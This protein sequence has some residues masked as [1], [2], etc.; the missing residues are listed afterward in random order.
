MIDDEALKNIERLHQLKTDGIISEEEFAQGKERLLFG[1]RPQR[2]AATPSLGKTIINPEIDEHLRW[3]LLPLKR[4]LDFEGRS[5]RREF[6]MFLLLFSALVAVLAFAAF[7]EM[8]LTGNA[9]AISVL[10]I[11]AIGIASLATVV[12]LLAVQV[13]RLHDQNRS[14][15]LVL[16]NMVPY[17]G[18]IIVLFLMAVEGTPGTN[19]F[20]ADPRNGG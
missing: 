3:A 16:I 19:R 11:L 8:G 15:W 18:A 12:P 1:A 10:A 9:G 17:V 6:W 4:F 2:A 14:G 5:S 13:R 20:G 7:I